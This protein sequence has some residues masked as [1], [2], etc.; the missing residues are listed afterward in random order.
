MDTKRFILGAA[1]LM[2]LGGCPQEPVTEIVEVTEIVKVPVYVEV[3]VAVPVVV[4]GRLDVTPT[5]LAACP[6]YSPA[7]IQ[8]LVYACE[9]DRLYGNSYATQRAIMYDFCLYNDPYPECWQCDEAIIDQVY[10]GL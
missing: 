9:N 8:E 10:L 3:P 6:Q 1:V 7:A 2:L 4:Y 5:L